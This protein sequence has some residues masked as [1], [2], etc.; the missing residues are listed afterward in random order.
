MIS[1]RST[2]SF[3]KTENTFCWKGAE[4][5]RCLL[6]H[7]SISSVLSFGAKGTLLWGD[8]NTIW[9]KMNTENGKIKLH[10]HI[11]VEDNLLCLNG[12]CASY[13]TSQPCTAN[14]Q[15][16][17]SCCTAHTEEMGSLTPNQ[18]REEIKLVPSL[19]WM[20]STCLQCL[21]PPGMW[22]TQRGDTEMSSWHAAVSC[23]LAVRCKNL[24]RNFPWQ[25][26]AISS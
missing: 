8:S 18:C 14:D 26:S 24:L 21:V 25:A 20:H 13:W 7:P 15:L 2:L 10:L 12:V 1:P 5:A 11:L 9:L 22:Q 17:H 16:R 3:N 4:P 23:S 19:V 6:P